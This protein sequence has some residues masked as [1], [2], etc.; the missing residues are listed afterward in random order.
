MP[1]A[2]TDGVTLHY[3][4]SGD[5][6]TVVFVTDAGYGAWLWGWHVDAVAGPYEA[7]VWDL[8]GTGESD[9]PAGPYDVNT[10][11]SDLEA[12]LSA[13]G[14]GSAHLVGAGLGGMVALAY[15]HRYNRARTLTLYNTAAA[16]EAL[17]AAALRDLSLDAGAEASLSGAFSPAFREE[18]ALVERIT[19]WRRAEDATG[20][21]FEAQVAAALAF[22]APPLYEVTLPTAVYYG[23]DDPVVPTAA[24]ESL[25]ADLPRGEATAVEGRHCSYVEHAP[26]VTDRLTA[27]LDEHADPGL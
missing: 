18:T 13:H 10:L 1:T 4:T 9:A 20:D 7:L 22:D 25:A 15:A 17:D 24:A 27:F 14:V 26:A 19:E 11:A 2:T 23:V 3:E 12:V 16:G 8:R 5:G 6:P 21:A